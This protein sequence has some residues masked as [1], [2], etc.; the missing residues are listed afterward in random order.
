MKRRRKMKT[1]LI[2]RKGKIG[3]YYGLIKHT[4]KYMGDELSLVK[5][6]GNKRKSRVPYKELHFLTDEEICEKI[7]LLCENEI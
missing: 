6:F 3:K 7:N 5:F 2:S 4:K 1:R